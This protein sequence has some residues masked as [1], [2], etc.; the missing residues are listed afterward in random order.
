MNWLGNI[1]SKHVDNNDVVLDLGCG[2][3]QATTDLYDHKKT[4][5][6]KTILGVEL[7]EKYCNVVKEKYPVIRTNVLHTEL[8]VNDSFDVVLCLDV[9]EH[10]KED[11]AVFL[12]NEMKRIARKKVIIYTPSQYITNEE[13]VDNAWGLGENKFQ[14][15]SCFLKPDTLEMLGFDVSFPEP[16]KNTLG[17]WKT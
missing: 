13:N 10:L 8:F 5:K 12:I 11:D 16:D 2:I 6:C 17:V 3:M 14:K 7:V 15:H 1:I 4:I 9:L